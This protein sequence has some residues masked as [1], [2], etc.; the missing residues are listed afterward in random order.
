[1]KLCC[2]RV[3][4]YMQLQCSRQQRRR[5]SRQ[6]P[7]VFTL[8]GCIAHCEPDRVDRHLRYVCL[9]RESCSSWFVTQTQIAACKF[10]QGPQAEQCLP[11]GIS[12]LHKLLLV[13]FK[14]LPVYL[15]KVLD[16]EHCKNCLLCLKRSLA[17]LTLFYCHSRA[18]YAMLLTCVI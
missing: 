12:V 14:E 11:R 13:H 18:C 3:K 8:L 10:T 15:C 1:V 9:V 16:F 6:G 2:S 4:P 5:C 7:C 17:V